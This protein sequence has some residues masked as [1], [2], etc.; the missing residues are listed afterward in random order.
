MQHASPVTESVP[1]V[2]ISEIEFD[3]TDP[4]FAEY[5][6]ILDKFDP[7]IHVSLATLCLYVQGDFYH[8]LLCMFADTVWDGKIGRR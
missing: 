4:T 8:L 3:E 6:T 5:K 2:R 7:R 1:D